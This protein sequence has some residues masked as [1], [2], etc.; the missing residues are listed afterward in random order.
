MKTGLRNACVRGSLILG[1]AALSA[2]SGNQDLAA[3]SAAQRLLV[4]AKQ[5]DGET[6]CSLLAS[7]A[8][9]ELEQT[10]GDPCE[11]AVLDEDLGSG[12]GSLEVH[13]F[14]TAAQVVVGAEVVFLS[15]FDGQWL[16]IAAACTPVHGRPYDCNV[17]MP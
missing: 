4:A 12:R 1:V 9:Q 6:A 10:T 11:E 13:V 15:R 14:D 8:R 5:G 7:A 2:C 17:G 16:V 3:G